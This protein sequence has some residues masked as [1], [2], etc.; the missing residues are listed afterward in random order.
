MIQVDLLRCLLTMQIQCLNIVKWKL[1]M[2]F[3]RRSLRMVP[4]ILHTIVAVMW[5]MIILSEVTLMFLL[6]THFW[7]DK[8]GH[9]LTRILNHQQNPRVNPITP[10]VPV[11]TVNP[12][13]RRQEIMKMPIQVH[14]GGHMVLDQ[15]QDILN[16][17][18]KGPDLVQEHQ[19]TVWD[20]VT[21][22]G[23]LL[24]L[25]TLHHQKEQQDGT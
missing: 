23:R 9:S 15:D 6:Q 19:I 2:T 13:L 25:G 1:L 8:G 20:F 14:L 18:P 17:V 12:F 22:V 4:D 5:Q 10:N 7:Q 3:R 16:M 11:F 21:L 24:N